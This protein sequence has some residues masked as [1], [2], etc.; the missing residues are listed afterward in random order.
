MFLRISKNIKI[1]LV[2]ALRKVEGKY[3]PR[4]MKYNKQEKIYGG[5]ATQRPMRKTTFL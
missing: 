1:V 5:T 2:F 3:L 4:L